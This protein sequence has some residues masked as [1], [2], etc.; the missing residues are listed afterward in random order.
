MSAI[1]KDL[2]DLQEKIE[3]IERE[4]SEVHLVLDRLTGANTGYASTLQDLGTA[5]ADRQANKA[6]WGEW[7]D[8]WFARVGIS[9]QPIG[10]EKM[11]AMM[12]GEGVRAE[13]SLLSTGIIAMREE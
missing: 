11:Q 7:L 8:E 1:Q 10:A 3:R 4:L 5:K 2:H 6:H 9:V 12:L 13:E